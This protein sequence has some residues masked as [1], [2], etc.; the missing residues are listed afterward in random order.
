MTRRKDGQ[1][2]NLSDVSAIL[3]YGVSGP[4]A[5]LNELRP[6]CLPAHEQRWRPMPNGAGL[7]LCDRRGKSTGWAL[8]PLP[9]AGEPGP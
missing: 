7:E 9:A 5:R 8:V 6:P 1:P 3:R 2:S 4:A